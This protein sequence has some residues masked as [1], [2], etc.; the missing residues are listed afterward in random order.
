ME[1][2]D[3]QREASNF[4]AETHL[5]HFK[6]I[7]EY[8]DCDFDAWTKAHIADNPSLNEKLVRLGGSPQLACNNHLLNSEMNSMYK[9]TLENRVG[10]TMN[11]CHKTMLA[12]RGSIKKY[13][14]LRSQTETNRFLDTSTC[15]NHCLMACIHGFS[16]SVFE[17]IFIQSST[18]RRSEERRV[19]D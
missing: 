5:K 18:R 2:D 3:N 11:T 7:F 12:T 4:K 13:A 15:C 10:K 19:D 1:T 17:R 8:Y 6:K 9:N 16:Y 14:C